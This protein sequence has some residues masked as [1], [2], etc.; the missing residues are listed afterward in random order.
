MAVKNLLRKPLREFKPYVVGKPIEAVRREYGLTGRIAKL[1]SNENPLGT[2]PLALEAMRRAVDEVSFYPDDGAYAYREK[3][4]RL[5]RVE[6]GNLYPASGSVEI[7]EIA[8]TAFLDPGD[9]V[10]SSEKTFAMYSLVTA[11][12]GA[13]F[14]A[15]P[16]CDGGYR[17]DLEAMARLVDESTKIVYLA[18]PTN[19]TGTWF[20]KTEFDRFMARVPEDVL[21]VYDSAYEEYTTAPDMPDP[22]A[23][24]RNGRRLLLI[25]TFSKAYGLAGIRIGYGVGP[26]DVINGLQTC[27]I[28]FNA[29]LVAQAGAV[30]ALD[31][32]EFV[33]R[34]KEHT[35]GELAF[36]R[37]GLT[38][39]PVI[40][41]PSQTNFLFIDLRKKASWIFE[42]LQK[43][44][45]IVRPVGP[46]AIRVST[47]LRED[48]EKFL[49]HFRRLVLSAEGSAD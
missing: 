13:D 21:V 32:Y 22:M 34:T 17:Y 43:I 6:L 11:K 1:A 28:P 19:P 8:A 7:I 45:V 2:S 10:V 35:L 15:A 40:V 26:L 33:R 12:A 44:G 27:R 16:M 9:S 20:D 42:E 14:R 38:G 36:L 47:G 46:R 29:N 4:A 23:H 39:L 37:Q 49:E 30:A 48:N 31:D 24:L 25:R 3:L 5:Y 18:N 41:P